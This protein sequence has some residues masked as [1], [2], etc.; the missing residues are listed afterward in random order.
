VRSAPERILVVKASSL[1]DIVHALPVGAALKRAFPESRLTWVVER[2][3][4]G[5]LEGNPYVDELLV[6]D[7]KR[8]KRR[9]FARETRREL[10]RFVRSLRAVRPDV[11]LDLQGLIKSGLIARG[12]GAPV[13]IGMDAAHARERTNVVFTNRRVRPRAEERHVV[14]QLLRAMECVGEEPPRAPEFPLWIGGDERAE[15]GRFLARWG[16]DTRRPRIAL[17]PGGGWETKRWG[18]ERYAALAD[19]IAQ[20]LEVTPVLL[21]GPGEET[22]VAEV[23]AR[24]DREAALIEP[25]DVKGLLAI[26][27][28]M[29]VV[30]AGDTGPLHMAAAL[31]VTAVGLFGPSD[32]L[33]NGPYGAGHRTVRAE[34]V[35]CLGCYKR[36]CAVRWCMEEL[37]VDAVLDVVLGTLGDAARREAPVRVALGDEAVD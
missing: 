5:I 8:W 25:V 33:R 24:M 21:W 13:R 26:L 32:P 2:M 28:R 29:D 37:R 34:R 1:G 7:F 20:T 12:S 9:P 22:L 18:A 27:E 31:G 10:V 4:V 17:S 15:A 36:T 23:R 19:R 30:V 14:D 16:L 3:G 35:P 11:A 6:S